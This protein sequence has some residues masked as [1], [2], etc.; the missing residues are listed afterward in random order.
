MK[1][2]FYH[3]IEYMQD[4]VI[5]TMTD[6]YIHNALKSIAFLFLILSFRLCLHGSCLVKP[7]NNQHN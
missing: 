6:Q 3:F 2:H 1:N 7:R 4:T 5:E